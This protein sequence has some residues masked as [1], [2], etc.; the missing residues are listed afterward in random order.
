MDVAAVFFCFVFVVVAIYLYVHMTG[1][2]LSYQSDSAL[3][4]TCVLRKFGANAVALLWSG[5]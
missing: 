1:V 4:A 5:P 3:C 2:K